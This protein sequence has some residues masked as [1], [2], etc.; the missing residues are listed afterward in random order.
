MSYYQEQ[1]QY[2]ELGGWF[3]SVKS[4][5]KDIGK[6]AL[7][8]FGEAKKR[9]GAAELAAQQAGAQAQP[10]GGPSW[11]LPVAIGGGVIAL[12]VLLTRRKK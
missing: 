9:E 1:G 11:I 8:I 5:G 3:D 7:E 6:G 2:Q 10:A 12:V 4:Y